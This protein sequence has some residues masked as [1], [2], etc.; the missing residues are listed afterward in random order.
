LDKFGDKWSL[1]IIRD[2]MFKN[3]RTYGEFLGSDEKIST[4]ILADR[5]ASLECA[6]LLTSKADDGNKS[7]KIYSLTPKAI[8]LV[9]AMVEIIKWS[10]TYDKKTAAEK[11]FVD[12]IKRDKESLVK[13]IT[14]SLKNLKNP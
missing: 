11:T 5:L 1:L 7:K 13:E 9:P 3:K 14:A 8:D 12:K 4:N 2:L 10:A 6:G